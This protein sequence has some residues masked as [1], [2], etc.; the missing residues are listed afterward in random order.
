MEPDTIT[1]IKEVPIPYMKNMFKGLDSS[2]FK[3]GRGIINLH[4]EDRFRGYSYA[5]MINA[6]FYGKD[7]MDTV[8]FAQEFYKKA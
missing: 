3:I 8:K 6:D 1:L 5:D 4:V 2:F 7:A